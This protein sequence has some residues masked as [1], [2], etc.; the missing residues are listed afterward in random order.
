[1]PLQAPYL[2]LP[3]FDDW[4]ERPVFEI[5]YYAEYAARGLRK[6]G[7]TLDAS[8]V[9]PERVF[10]AGSRLVTSHVASPA[11]SDHP[12]S[13]QPVFAGVLVL[14]A[15]AYCLILCYFRGYVGALVK[16]LRGRLYVEMMLEESNHAFRVFLRIA[17]ALGMLTSAAALVRIAEA[18]GGQ[19]LAARLPA[20]AVTGAVIIVAVGL[21]AVMLYRWTML[22]IAGAVT[23]R[24]DFVAKFWCLRGM[25]TALGGLLATPLLLLVVL[26]DGLGEQAMEALLLVL[27]VVGAV[28]VVVAGVRL[29]LSAGVSILH[30]FLYLCAVEIF[31]WSLMMGWMAR[32]GF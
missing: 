5:D 24:G 6:D 8:L 18:Y 10:G 17:T 1:M 2:A 20:W 22:G 23:L 11:V 19:A 32:G 30:W 7:A 28:G 13:G 25:V 14:V 15:L 3:P 27:V 12:F 4:V 21:G 16:L 29:F 26:N 9:A 31:P